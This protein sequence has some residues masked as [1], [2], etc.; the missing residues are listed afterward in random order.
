MDVRDRFDVDGWLVRSAA[1]GSDT[2]E[3]LVAAVDEVAGWASTGG[4][5]LHH[6]ELTDTGPAIA[7][8]EDF[9][10]RQPVLTSVIRAGVVPEVVDILF[11]EPSTLFKEKINYKHPGGAGFAPHQDAAAY[12]FVDRHI[13]C[14]V[15]L[16]PATVDSGCL[17]VAAGHRR[18]LLPTDERGC[19]DAAIAAALDWEPVELAPGDLLFFDSFT[20]HY[21]DGNSTSRARR[22]LYLTYNAASAGD[23]RS[24]YYD[25]KRHTLAAAAAAL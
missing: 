5:G 16:D 14:M 23:H 19:I 1:L 8:S 12:R 15:P 25:D 2:V 9:V 21:S 11:G 22:A 10:D 20:P 6:F 18:G 3:A 7:R 17:H 4:P 24:V 13:S